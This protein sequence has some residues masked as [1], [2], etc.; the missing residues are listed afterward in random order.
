MPS[1][2]KKAV[3]ENIWLKHADAIEK[4]GVKTIK[5]LVAELRSGKVSRPGEPGIPRRDAL[6][7]LVDIALSSLPMGM[8]FKE[9]VLK[10]IK[11]TPDKITF[12]SVISI[13]ENIAKNETID[14][15]T[16]ID[17]NTAINNAKTGKI[18]DPFKATM[19]LSEYVLTS[20]I[21]QQKTIREVATTLG[22]SEA[23]A[24]KLSQYYET[25]HRLIQSDTEDI[26]TVTG[27]TSK[28]AALIKSALSWRQRPGVSDRLASAL[29][30]A[31]IDTEIIITMDPE[32]L[33]SVVSSTGMEIPKAEISDETLDK[34]IEA[35][36]KSAPALVYFYDVITFLSLPEPALQFIQKKEIRSFDRLRLNGL[37][38]ELIKKGRLN[39]ELTMKLFAFSRLEKVTHNSTLAKS[40]IADDITSAFRVSKLPIKELK[41][42][43]KG[44]ASPG[45]LDQAHKNA[46]QITGK[47]MTVASWAYVTSRNLNVDEM[48]PGI[49]DARRHA[50]QILKG[51]TK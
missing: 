47:T 14:E 15:Q 49:V 10:A 19:P 39:K 13:L 48:L 50:E 28:Q 33:R 32:S 8:L 37:M 38:N 27:I 42:R 44:K 4:S 51:G 23:K 31:S 1:K 2:N 41:K 7:M 21:I 40:L 24:T 34:I 3:K 11:Q 35:A 43:Y 26:L 25:P 36:K 29:A 20:H 6:E 18:K 45:E 16:R 17:L 5:D 12:S 46:V 22:I 30:Q 9:H